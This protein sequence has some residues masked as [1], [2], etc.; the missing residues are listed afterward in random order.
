MPCVLQML[1]G[2]PTRS[3]QAA[4]AADSVVQVV[5][6]ELARAGLPTCIQVSTGVLG[7]GCAGG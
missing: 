6:C 2:L 7:V 4:G 3:V 1:I 5:C